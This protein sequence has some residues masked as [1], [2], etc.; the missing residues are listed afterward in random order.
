MRRRRTALFAVFAALFFAALALQKAAAAHPA[1]VEYLYS[2]GLYPKLAGAVGT[3]F[4]LFPFSCAELLL[5]CGLIF[6]A[7]I[8]V[9]AVRLALKRRR[10]A[11]LRLCASVLCTASALYFVFTAVWGLNYD[12]LPLEQNLGYRTGNPTVSELEAVMEQETD[13]VNSLCG[14]VSY[15]GDH[16]V[17]PGGFSKISAGVNAGYTALSDEGPVQRALFGKNRPH[18]KGIL[19]SKLMSYTGIE[20]IFIPFTFEANVDTAS[21]TFVLPFDAA[22]ES[23]HFKGFA[24]EQE[25]NFIAYLADSANPDPYFRYSA[26]MEAYIYVSNA[27][28]STD[29]AAWQKLAK[30]LDPRAVGDLEFYNDYVSAHQSRASDVSNKINDSYLK[31]Q[32]QR[33]VVTYDMFVT[34]LCDRYRT[35]DK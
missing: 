6:C 12:R 7:F 29:N 35:G 25:A 23:A 10:R 34:I 11:L 14:S 17:Y 1:A 9:L 18:P 5:Y 33:G 2:R 28:Y 15:S 13:A 4:N 16:S 24:R 30:R 8:L 21:P 31:S 26:H 22:H 20:G 19:A 27:L 3:Y 32:G